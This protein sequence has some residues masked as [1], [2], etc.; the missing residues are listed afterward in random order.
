MRTL[1]E[2]V[3]DQVLKVKR[4]ETWLSMM[5]EQNPWSQTRLHPPFSSSLTLVICLHPHLKKGLKKQKQI[6]LQKCDGC[7]DDGSLSVH[8]Q[9]L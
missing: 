2:G 6:Q 4:K 1:D 3:G 9:V 8:F 5:T 7:D